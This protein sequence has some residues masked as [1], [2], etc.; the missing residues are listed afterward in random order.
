MIGENIYKRIQ[1][2]QSQRKVDLL[3]SH[4]DLG[5]WSV[6]S[7]LWSGHSCWQVSDRGQGEVWVHLE[8][9]T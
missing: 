5:V 3:V 4:L 8:G 1:S 9:Y 6:Y 2:V 7:G